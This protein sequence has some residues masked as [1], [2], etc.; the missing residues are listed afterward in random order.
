MAIQRRHHT[1]FYLGARDMRK[2]TDKHDSVCPQLDLVNHFDLRRPDIVHPSGKPLLTVR[3]PIFI[4][5]NR[6]TRT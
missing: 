4:A 5:E 1:H 3:D 2:L 6:R